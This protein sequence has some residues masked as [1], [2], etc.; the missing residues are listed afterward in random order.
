MKYLI[1]TDHLSIL[2][3]QAGVE[4]VILSSRIAQHDPNDFALSIIGFHEQLLGCHT[5]LSRARSTT[6][7]LRGYDMLLRLQ[8]DYQ[9]ANLL[10][11]D[12]AAASK[13]DEL[14]GARLRVGTMDLR[15]A[16]IAL[17]SGRVLLSRN[18]RDFC[19]IP[20]LVL[21]DWTV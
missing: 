17:V 16:A 8:S 15:I 2:Q 6:E 4:F 12:D 19:K 13:Y 10:P 3:E 11:F 14:L 9:T 21:E 7:L 1:D 18:K 5:Y 20:G